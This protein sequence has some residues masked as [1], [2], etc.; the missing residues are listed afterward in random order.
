[1]AILAFD[2]ATSACSAAVCHE[3][4]ILAQRYA[5]MARGQSEALV[6]MI[7]EVMGEAG[8]E[9][10]ALDALAVTVGP[11]A[12]TGIR[13]GL[14]TA[15]GLALVHNTPII[16]ISTLQAVVAAIPEAERASRVTL[17]VVDS[18][19][20]ELWMQP[21][22]PDLTPL[23]EA[24]AIV[25]DEIENFLLP[26][27]ELYPQ[28]PLLTDRVSP[29]ADIVAKLAESL[30]LQGQSGFAPQPLY[31]RDADVT[32]ANRKTISAVVAE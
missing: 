22:A 13:I 17:A 24:A 7:A 14:A 32:M 20:A 25:P 5:E 23:A 11:G 10:A 15:R 30:W 31:L 3:G 29:R 16:G 12:F 26:W 4:A 8:L 1:M 9:F 28:E 6:P 2:T 19:R 21:F 27:K 18:R